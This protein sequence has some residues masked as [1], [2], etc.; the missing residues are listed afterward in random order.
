MT[1]DAYMDA[2]LDYPQPKRKHMTLEEKA[3]AIVGLEGWV[4]F[5]FERL[6]NGVL[7]TGA[8][9]PLVTRGPRKGQPNYRK[10]DPKTLKKV[11][12]I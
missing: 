4:P 11:A 10:R 5:I 12:V 6:E 3:A 2:E 8:V 7:V 1:G 9:C